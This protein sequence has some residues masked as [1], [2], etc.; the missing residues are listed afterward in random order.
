MHLSVSLFVDLSLCI[1]LSLSEMLYVFVVLV[2]M[3]TSASMR[4]GFLL[5]DYEAELGPLNAEEKCADRGQ[6]GCK[7]N[8]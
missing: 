1:Y 7:L 4:N 8:I 5:R 3:H 2:C 6:I